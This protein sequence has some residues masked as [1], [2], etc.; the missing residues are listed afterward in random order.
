MALI[1]L[2]YFSDDPL[3]RA[4]RRVMLTP[5][6]SES[7]LDDPQWLTLGIAKDRQPFAAMLKVSEG[8]S[9]AKTPMTAT[10]WTLPTDV[11]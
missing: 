4:F 10:P 11:T 8:S 1:G 3:K 5:G 7:A 6:E 9:E 2:V